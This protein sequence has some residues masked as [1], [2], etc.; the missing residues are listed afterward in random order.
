MTKIARKTFKA[1]DYIH[2]RIKA[3]LRQPSQDDKELTDFIVLDAETKLPLG[4]GFNWYVNRVKGRSN[5]NFSLRYIEIISEL[6]KK[7]KMKS[8]PELVRFFRLA[9]AD[10]KSDDM[11]NQIKGSIL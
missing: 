11:V 4:M 3:A 5:Q 6:I 7:L 9:I 1:N 10:Q 2:N 8:E